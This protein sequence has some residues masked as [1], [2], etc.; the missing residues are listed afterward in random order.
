M[1]ND[2]AGRRNKWRT[3]AASTVVA[4][5]SLAAA[6]SA[7]AHDDDGWKWKH[8]KHQHF[9]PPGHV[10]YAPPVYYAPRP[11]HV[12]PAPVYYMPPPAYYPPP[13]VNINIPLR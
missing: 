4:F 2:V 7:S 11:V 6:T 1:N 9:V 10:N 13:G 8:R 12:H 5:A 3:I